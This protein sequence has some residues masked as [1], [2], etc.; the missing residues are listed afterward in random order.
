M[1]VSKKFKLRN[2]RRGHKHKYAVLES[3][4]NGVKFQCATCGK[5]L[6][7]RR[8]GLWAMFVW[9]FPWIKEYETSVLWRDGEDV[10]AYY[11]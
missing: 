1:M 8:R 6:Y 2:K 9:G 4:H 10:K 3:F 5:K 11:G 7:M